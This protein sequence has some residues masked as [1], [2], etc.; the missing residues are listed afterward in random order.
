MECGVI[1]MTK[2]TLNKNFK[3]HPKHET[4]L[5]MV[6]TALIYFPELK[7]ITLGCYGRMGGD[8]CIANAEYPDK[9]NFNIKYIPSYVTIFHEL[10]HQ[11]QHIRVAPSGEKQASIFGIARLP[12]HLADEDRLPYVCLAPRI[13]LR[14]YC[15]LA[16]KYKNDGIKYYIKEI[17]K[18]IDADIRAD[19]DFISGSAEA[20]REDPFL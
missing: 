7:T 4:I 10:G 3:Y 8:R 9:L 19:I 6:E 18:I 17:E 5:N 12:D 14:Y 2:I 1:K 20:Q 11:L 16:I 13:K 15:N